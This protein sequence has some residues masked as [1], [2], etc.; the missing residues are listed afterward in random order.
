MANCSPSCP[1]CQTSTMELASRPEP[2]LCSLVNNLIK[3]WKYIITK[4]YLSDSSVSYNCHSN[5]KS[6]NTLLRKRSV[7]NSIDTIFFQKTL[8]TSENTSKFY[9]LSEYFCSRLILFYVESV[10]RATSIAEFIDWNKFIC[11]LGR[12]VGISLA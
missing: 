1:Y 6:S 8:G 4:L 10:A 7:K 5:C 12:E 3:S 11:Y 2:I 9:I